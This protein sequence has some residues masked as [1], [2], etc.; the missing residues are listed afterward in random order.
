MHAFSVAAHDA[1]TAVSGYTSLDLVIVLP[2]LVAAVAII[3]WFRPS[4]ALFVWLCILAPLCMVF[5]AR[6]LMSF[7]RFLLPLFPLFWAGARATERKYLPQALVV[8]ASAAGLGLMTAL[9]VNSY[10]V[11]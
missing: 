8:G 6:P 7:P 4:Y 10:Y 1:Q 9:F 3:K 2:M 5:D 11:F